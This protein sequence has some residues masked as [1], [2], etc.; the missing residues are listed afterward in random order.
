[1]PT[2]SSQPFFF[3]AVL[4]WITNKPW[5]VIVIGFVSTCFFAFHIPELSFRTSV[6]DLLIKDLPDTAVYENFKAE[7][8]SD[9]VIRLVVKTDHIF[10]PAAFRR[11]ENIS[12]KLAGLDGIRRVISLPQI[13]KAIDP[14]AKMSLTQ[15]ETVV[16][17]VELFQR[18]LISADRKQTAITLILEN[19]AD[20]ES[21]TSAVDAIINSNA[22]HFALYQIGMP[23]ISR[24]LVNHTV[25][26]FQRLPVFTFALIAAALFILLRRHSQVLLPLMCVS[27]VLVWTFGFMGLL[28]LK[29]SLLTMI[30]PVFIIAVGT[31]YSL[32]TI[33][34]YA[35]SARRAVSGPDAVAATYTHTAL[36]CALAVFT[37]LFGLG[38]L[39]INRIPAIDEFALFACFGM[40]SLLCVMLTLLPAVLVLIPLPD[41]NSQKADR[42]V[43]GL[44]RF[45]DWIIRLNLNHR[46]ATLSIIGLT[47]LAA[48]VGIFFIR[49][50]TNPVEY[51]RDD[52]PVSRN[53][54]DI[55]RSLS[56]SFPVNVTI[57]STETDYFENSRHMVELKRLQEFLETLP[58]VDKTISFADYLML[59]NYTLNHYES[60]YYALPVEDFEIRMAINNYKTILGADLYSRFMSPALNSANILMLTHLSSSGEFLKTREAILTF[61]RQHFPRHLKVAVTGFG[62]AVSASSQLLTSGQ[63]KSLSIS[64]FLIFGIMFLMFLSAKVGLIA[65]LPNCFPILMNFGIMGWLGIKLSMVTGLIASIAIGLA[66]DDTIHYLH[67]YNFEFRKDLDKDRALRDTIKQVGKPIVITSL[68]ISIGFLVL[69]FSQFK[70]TAIFGFLM[71][72]TMATALIGDL[73]IL[74]S[75][76]LRVE[77]VTAW[78]LMKLMPSLGSMSAGIVH[79]LN[80]PLTAIKMGSE[81]L[82]MMI[83]Q[84]ANIK[85]AQLS[86]IATEISDQVDRVSEIINRLSA[87]GQRPDFK[88]ELVDINEPVRD[89]MAI[90]RLQLQVDDI[91]AELDLAEN[92]PPVWGHKN[93]LAQVVYNL[94]INA[95]EAIG[96]GNQSSDDAGGGHVIRICT[97]CE[98]DQVALT[99]SDTGPGIAQ[100][101]LGRI[102]EPFFTTKATGQAKGLGLSISNEI[103]RDCGGRLKIYSEQMKG[104]TFRVTLPRTRRSQHRKI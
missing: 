75:L 50:E 83:S 12:A 39:F 76:M 47:A 61:A 90:V 59:V 44:D 10:E 101:N 24:A 43:A 34:E 48:A 25:H 65:I 82:K 30:V 22:D 38:A 3:P 11:L 91:A 23:L 72:I 73:I 84:K 15:F 104:A 8:G 71:V 46:K 31:A 19:D 20:Q 78:D 45:L 96:A 14:S 16:A 53:F 93:R 28:Q 29:L 62:M 6:Y 74:P 36:P 77:L 100:S 35:V 37:T 9:E 54:H 57:K 68:T 89:V 51:F 85:T 88:K 79:E 7:F 95:Y 92:L 87:F 102:L 67:R 1:M 69:M 40:L 70:P 17:P 99:V 55:Y 94:V 4:K 27:V 63:V 18:N 42:M 86:Q 26:D 66:V 81:F 64:L 21:V 32:H 13:K 33:S 41:I 5:I 98:D 49:I 58:K 103:I 52:A 2:S 97:S 60:K 80:Q 56:G